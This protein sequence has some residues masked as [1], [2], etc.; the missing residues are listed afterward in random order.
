MSRY[1]GIDGL[2]VKAPKNGWCHH[3]QV[4]QKLSISHNSH[5]YPQNDTKSNRELP[6]KKYHDKG[7]ESD[8]H[9]IDWKEVILCNSMGF[10]RLTR[11]CDDKSLSILLNP[12]LFSENSE[13]H[14]FASTSDEFVEHTRI[15][16]NQN[17]ENGTFYNI[18]GKQ[19]NEIRKCSY[20][21]PDTLFL[22]QI[23]NEEKYNGIPNYK[24]T[25][26]IFSARGMFTTSLYTKKLVS[27]FSYWTFCRCC[28]TTF[29]FSTHAPGDY[30][31]ILI[32]STLLC[33][34]AFDTTISP[35]FHLSF[36]RLEGGYSRRFTSHL[37]T[38]SPSPSPSNVN[39][40]TEFGIVLRNCDVFGV[41]NRSEREDLAE[42]TKVSGVTTPPTAGG[43]QHDG[44]NVS[45]ADLSGLVFDC[46][47]M[48]IKHG[49][50][51][52][53]NN[54][55]N[56]INNDRGIIVNLLLICKALP[57]AKHC[58]EFIKIKVVFSDGY[59]NL[60]SFC[61][62]RDTNI[63][64]NNNLDIKKMLNAKNESLFGWNNK[65]A[66]FKTECVKIESNGAYS[67][68]R[69]QSVIKHNR[70]LIMVINTTSHYIILYNYEMN[71]YAILK[72]NSI[73]NIN[74]NKIFPYVCVYI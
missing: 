5:S 60:L 55:D 4:E 12:T 19:I 2:N 23:F 52:N 34:I 22:T 67:K 46:V 50:D 8:V 59:K 28:D 49:N 11:H 62:Q 39:N 26:Q 41:E 44:T 15:N 31:H 61:C 71:N 7:P 74:S 25:E 20:G 21:L 51:S 58:F 16:K 13:K 33:V 73:I 29:D 48:D 24:K 14:H 10:S 72:L 70:M 6:F 37:I 3:E 36:R 66:R 30:K 53:N 40:V 35:H 38:P 42:E 32:N 69:N 57:H 63:A 27:N 54:D 17:T 9:A 47:L 56:N 43:D 45:S 65:T 64:I 68:S 18:E 1:Q